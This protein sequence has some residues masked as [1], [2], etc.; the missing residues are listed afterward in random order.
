MPAWRWPSWPATTRPRCWAPSRRR[1]PAATRAPGPR[2]DRRPRRPA[3]AR[4]AAAGR[5]GDAATHAAV[6]ALARRDAERLPAQ[7]PRQ[8][9]DLAAEG[10]TV[11]RLVTSP[12]W[13]TEQAA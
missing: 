8:L 9:E 5:V 13:R 7:T 11:A 2:A 4:A 1:A 10:L 3:G 6:R 12:A